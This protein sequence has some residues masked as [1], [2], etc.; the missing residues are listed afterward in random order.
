MKSIDYG[1]VKL[2]GQILIEELDLEFGLWIPSCQP[3]ELEV[4]YI[5]QESVQ[6]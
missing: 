5:L 6:K 2:D 4:G 1:L 3:K